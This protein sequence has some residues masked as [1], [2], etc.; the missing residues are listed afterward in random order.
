[1]KTSITMQDFYKLVGK[2]EE[3]IKNGSLLLRGTGITSLPDN[4]TVGGYLLLRGTGIT[5]IPGN[6]TVGGSLD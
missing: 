2:T 6:L 3:E 1:M 5:S 4:L